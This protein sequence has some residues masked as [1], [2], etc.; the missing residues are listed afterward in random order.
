MA[1]SWFVSVCYGEFSFYAFTV[2]IFQIVG[3][4]LWVPFSVS[5]FL[6]TTNTYYY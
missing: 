6:Y 1:P 5:H 2:Y 3:A 4:N